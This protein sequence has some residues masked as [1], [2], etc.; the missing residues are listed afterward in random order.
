MEIENSLKGP[1]ADGSEFDDNSRTIQP[2]NM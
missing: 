1:Q 2:M